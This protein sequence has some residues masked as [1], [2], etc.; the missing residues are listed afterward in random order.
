LSR[1]DLAALAADR[2]V[3]VRSDADVLVLLSTV[4]A[5]LTD[6]QCLRVW[7]SADEVHLVST[8]PAGLIVADVTRTAAFQLLAEVPA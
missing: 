7:L 4:A 2:P 8:D 3:T 1:R 5:P 6:P